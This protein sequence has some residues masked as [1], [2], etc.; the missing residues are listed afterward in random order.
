MSNETI[1]DLQCGGLKIIQSNDG[2]RFGTD[3]ILL[4]DFAKKN[5]AETILDLCTGNGI[6]P[7]LLSCKSN[8]KQIFGIEIQKES[9]EL[10]KRSISL[11]NLENRVKITCGDLKNHLKFYKK[12]SFDMITCNP[13]Y[14]KAGAAIQNSITSKTIARHEILCTIED[15]MIAAEN[16]LKPNGKIFMVHRPTRIADVISSMKTHRIEPKRLRFVY[17]DENSEP[18]LFLIEGLIFGKAE[19]RIMPPLFLKDKNGNESDELKKIY[20]RGE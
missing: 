8:A 9:A 5:Y 1:E 18:I 13:P 14:M 12:R 7:L 16:L 6:I 10:A 2:F 3:A 4:V 17:P 20:N 19:T 15:V 11:N